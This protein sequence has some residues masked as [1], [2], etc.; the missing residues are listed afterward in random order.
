[1]A[2]TPVRRRLVEFVVAVT[3]LHAVAIALYH[4][5]DI[6]GRST[7]MQERYAWVWLAFAAAVTLIGLRRFHRARRA[8]A[9]AAVGAPP[10]PAGPRPTRRDP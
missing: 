2:L 3:V 8:A 9:R 1:M 7:E 5:L 10:S 4:A 6:Q